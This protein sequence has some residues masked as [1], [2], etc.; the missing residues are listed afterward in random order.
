MSAPLILVAETQHDMRHIVRDYLEQSGFRA[1]PAV[2]PAD[3]F[4]AVGNM[5]VGAVVLDASLRNLDG[6]HLC[7]DVRERSDVPIILI[8]ADSS[9]VD[10]VVGLELGADDYMNRPYSTRELAARLRAVLRRGRGDRAV[11]SRPEAE[12]R[13]AGWVMDFAR[14]EL[15]NPAGEQVALTAGEFAL[16]TVLVDH[17]QMAIAR[18]RLMELAGVRDGASTTRSVDVLVSRIRRKLSHGGRPAPIVTLRGAGY[19]F[20]AK[21]ERR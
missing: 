1:L 5:P 2:S 16:L 18:A 15:S 4:N 10:R 12:A 14:R 20:S 17:P 19:M 21:V 3:I 6:M 8:G 9:E 11:T 7:R 13:F